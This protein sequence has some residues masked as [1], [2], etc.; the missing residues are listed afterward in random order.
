MN[1]KLPFNKRIYMLDPVWQQS[2]TRLG[3][4]SRDL[5]LPK[6]C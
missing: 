2:P 3:I 4:W 1:P 6:E 5:G